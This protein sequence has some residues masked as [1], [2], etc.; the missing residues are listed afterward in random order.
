MST[1]G[2]GYVNYSSGQRYTS[3]FLTRGSVAESGLLTGMSN[4]G[5][6]YAVI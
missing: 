4:C 2:E 3:Q 1:I 6:S 5:E